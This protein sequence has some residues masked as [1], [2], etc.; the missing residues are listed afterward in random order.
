MPHGVSR[1]ASISN[2]S[3]GL[4]RCFAKVS[5]EAKRAETRTTRARYPSKGASRTGRPSL[6]RSLEQLSGS[7]FY[8]RAVATG[9]ACCHFR[10]S[11]AL[12]SVS[13]GPSIHSCTTSPSVVAT[14]ST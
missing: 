1:K 11:R 8:L 7:R 9:M 6:L 12:A 2:R 3:S 13:N 4:F 14:E 10:H 5:W